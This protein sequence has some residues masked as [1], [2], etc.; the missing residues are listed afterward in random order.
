M[1]LTLRKK[2]GETQLVKIWLL[3]RFPVFFLKSQNHNFDLNFDSVRFP[4]LFPQ[5]QN[6]NF[7]LNFDSFHF[8]RFS[9]SYIFLCWSSRN[10]YFSFRHWKMRESCALGNWKRV[11][12][13]R[14]NASVQHWECQTGSRFLL[15]SNGTPDGR[16]VLEIRADKSNLF[17]GCLRFWKW[18]RK[19]ISQ[20]GTEQDHQLVINCLHSFF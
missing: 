16:T 8:T 15:W 17:R 14:C 20:L 9:C 10:G 12:Y 13:W 4:G 5:S 1:V 3:F 11:N 6:H 7:D 2:A 18:W 19:S